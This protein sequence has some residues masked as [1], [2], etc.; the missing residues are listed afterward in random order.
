VAVRSGKSGGAEGGSASSG[1]GAGALT[2]PARDDPPPAR[3]VGAV[4]LSD[5]VSGAAARTLA[6]LLALASLVSLLL[7]FA[8]T[9]AFVNLPGAVLA[10]WGV[11]CLAQVRKTAT[12]A[13]SPP[14]P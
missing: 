12:T 9:N 14:P 10:V 11:R 7:T 2:P 1:M 13:T 6:Q 3:G 5:A 4:T 8:S